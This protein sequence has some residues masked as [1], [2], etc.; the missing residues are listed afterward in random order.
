MGWN[1]LFDQN[2]GNKLLSE[3][4]DTTPAPTG[5]PANIKKFSRAQ[6]LDPLTE[7]WDTVSATI[8]PQTAPV[9]TADETLRQTLAA[10]STATWTQADRDN[11]LQLHL[12]SLRF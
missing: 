1:Y 8:K 12:K 7:T 4:D 9:A 5:L 11:A 10:K 2:A 6:R 3:Y